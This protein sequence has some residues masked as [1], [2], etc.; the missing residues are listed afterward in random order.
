MVYSVILIHLTSI[1]CMTAGDGFFVRFIRLTLLDVAFDLQ[2]LI[3]AQI[4][5]IFRNC[6]MSVGEDVTVLGCSCEPGHGG[7]QPRERCAS[8]S[9][10]KNTPGK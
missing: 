9:I 3:S 10:G 5:K 6:I 4:L 7:G 8:N 2:A 1:I